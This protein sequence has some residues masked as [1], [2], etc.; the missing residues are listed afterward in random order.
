MGKNVVPILF[1]QMA[2][3]NSV[4][5]LNKRTLAEC[6][7]PWHSTGGLGEGMTSHIKEC[8]NSVPLLPALNIL[9]GF[10]DQPLLL[11]AALSGVSAVLW[12]SVSFLGF[13]D[14]HKSAVMCSDDATSISQMGKASLRPCG[15][16]RLR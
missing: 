10:L 11:E 15:I 14:L 9:Q 12:T 8:G 5:A 6:P 16:Y 4:T 7:K 13:L 1:C 2:L 3:F